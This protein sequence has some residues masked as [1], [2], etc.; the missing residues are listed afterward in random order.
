VFFIVPADDE[1][2]FL[3]INSIRQAFDE[4]L[5]SPIIGTGSNFNL[6]A[7]LNTPDGKCIHSSIAQLAHFYG[8][9][10]IIIICTLY[11]FLT[12][13]FSY[14]KNKQIN[15]F[16]FLSIIAIS[17]GG[18]I[19]MFPSFWFFAGYYYFNITKTLS[20]YKNIY[21]NINNHGSY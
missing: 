19:M 14:V 21:E 10:G 1:S 3:R 11:W 12:P 16:I 17:I 2:S 9:G 4:L 18:A 7:V 20:N 13:S 8:I 15:C 5:A 6:T